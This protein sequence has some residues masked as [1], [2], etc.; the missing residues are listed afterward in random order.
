LDHIPHFLETSR[1][2][3]ERFKTMGERTFEQLSEEEIHFTYA[4]HDFSVALIVKHMVGNMLSRWTNF[5]TEDGEKDWRNRETEFEAPYSTKA[6]MLAAWET[7]WSCLFNAMES[8]NRSNMDKQVF[9]RGQAHTITQALLRQ[10]AHY[11]SHIGQIMFLGKSIKGTQWQSLSIPKG[12][13]EAF[14][15]K[16]FNTN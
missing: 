11:P 15:K 5:L 7:G 6:E 8:I 4:P 13:S 3:F 14:N 16:M 9:I 2:E 12:E 1:K 10:L